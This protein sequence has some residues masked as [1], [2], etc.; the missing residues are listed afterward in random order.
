MVPR[1]PAAVPL[2][3]SWDSVPGAADGPSAV[4]VHMLGNGW[5]PDHLGGLERYYR[6]L[7]ESLPEATGTVIGAGAHT[8]GRV[9][10]A[11][12]HD[13]ALPRRLAAYWRA[14]RGG[15]SGAQVID[16]H[17][18]LYAL[19]PLRVGPLRRTPAVV[20]FQGP[21]ADENTAAGDGSRL[22]HRARAAIER[23]AYRHADEAVVLSSA[24]RRVLVERYGVAPWQVNVV[25][26]G[27]DL[28]RFTPGATHRARA[29]LGLP[30]AGFIAV[31]VRRLVPRMGLESLL[32]AWASTVA[33]LPPDSRLLIAG[34]G[35]LRGA[36][37][38]QV[39]RSGIG[40]SVRL[41]GRVSDDELV[42][43]YRAA[44]V[45]V[46]PTL[47][48]E[49]FGLV[50]LEAA[51]C[52][53]PSVVTAVGGLPE[54]VAGL[55]PTLVV[56]PGDP[57]ALGERL[58]RASHS[59][60][61][62]ASARAHAEH[63][64]WPAVA[65]R[66][67]AIH[68]RV[69]RGG[70]ADE[71]LKVVYL[72][73]VARMS[74][75]E[76]ALLRLLPHLEGV[77]PHVVLAEDGPL[78]GA[79]DLAGVSS[80][81]LPLGVR[82]VDLRK[83]D[84]RG[85]TIPAGVAGGAAAYVLR[86]ARRLRQLQPDVV[87]ANSLKSGVYGSLA[88][89]L[90]GVPM[91]WHVRDR[92]DDDYLPASAV[93]LVRSLSRGLPTAIIA[94]SQATAQTL[95]LAPAGRVRCSVLPDVIGAAPPRERT[96]GRP[97]TY[98]IVGRLAPWKGQP[99]FLRA[100]ASAFPAGDERAVVVGG[101]L[102][103]EDA[104]ARGLRDVARSLGIAERVD[105]RGHRADVWDE[106]SQIDVLVHASVTPEPFGQVI[107]EGMAAGVP[108]IAANAGGPAEI[109]EHDV[110]GLLCAPGDETALATSILRMRDPHL[111]DRLSAAGRREVLRYA[112]A[113]VAAEL[114]ALYASVARPRRGRG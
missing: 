20:H 19:L 109:L 38:A 62:P 63:F 89:R 79:L 106:L 93:R 84:V 92:I 3:P 23:A 88:A 70:A 72:D 101:A 26:P 114:E 103:G 42:Q 27:I 58:L 2:T 12:E 11:S 37:T 14:A 43:L 99:V 55:D 13:R 30:S 107:L 61:D 7:L 67:R 94:N 24:F 29:D 47:E 59:R 35:P 60:P 112:P 15:A 102:F 83:D 56:P 86:L 95:T 91:I 64:S 46:V 82:T 16:A 96:S 45:G 9:V 48:Q 34:E 100:F 40:G 18:A 5:F 77:Q 10:G 4:R 32:E 33:D 50:V 36:L 81:V 17:F 108:V 87:H 71:R 80:E 74:G 68:R 65:E 53:T 28:E 57:Q 1:E 69:A 66:H 75:G 97:L 31:T 76:I 54:A 25:P 98:G 8:P 51:A 105:F 78:V 39:E 111:R 41:L 6:D 113:A 22:R 73:H 85:M 21:W 52:G 90:A 110:T 44:D 49:G 104:Y